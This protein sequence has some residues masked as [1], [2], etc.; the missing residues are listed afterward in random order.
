MD[1][2]IKLEALNRWIIQS[3]TSGLI[4]L[5]NQNRVILFNPAA[6]KIFGIKTSEAIGNDITR[7]FPFLAEY[8]EEESGFSTDNA[9]DS[10][11][12]ID[13]NYTGKNGTSTFL[14]FFISP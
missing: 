11:G 2:L 4:T 10:P 14:R 13:L 5:D 9:I 6:E 8:M 12:F 1:D 3:I 7:L